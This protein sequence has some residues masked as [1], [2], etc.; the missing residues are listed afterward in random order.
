MEVFHFGVVV[1]RAF[2]VALSWHCDLQDAPCFSV[3]VILKLPE[4]KNAGINNPA[5]SI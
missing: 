3:G 2:R 4:M 1:N 5:L